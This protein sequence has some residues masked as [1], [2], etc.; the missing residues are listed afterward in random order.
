MACHKFLRLACAAG[1]L[2]LGVPRHAPAHPHVWVDYDVSVGG[3]KAGITKLKFRWHFDEMFSSMIMGNFAIKSITPR[4]VETLRTK[5]FANLRNYHYFIHAKLDS[6]VFEP[7]DITDFGAALKGKNLEYT[8]TVALPHATQNLEFSLY[9]TEFYVDIGP[10]IEE[11]PPDPAD[12]TAP[13]TM[14]PKPFLSSFSEDTSTPPVCE[15]HQ[16]EPR[17]SETWGN[18]VVFV[19]TC[20]AATRAAGI[21]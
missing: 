19:I 13:P 10:P 7:E 5:A 3:T 11:T 18:F 20:R 9:D 16:G 1:L 21:R 2:T 4:D 8:F 6:G 12:T 17:T 14:K 15:Q